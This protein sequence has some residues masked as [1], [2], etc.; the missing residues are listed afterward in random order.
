MQYRNARFLP[1]GRINCEIEHPRHGWIPFT[2]SPDDDRDS[3]RAVHAEIVA[4]GTA[5]PYVHD[6]VAELAEF[7]AM[8]ACTPLQFMLALGETR[9]NRVEAMMNR[10]QTGWAMKQRMKAA[11]VWKRNSPVVA[12]VQAELGLTDIQMDD[13]FKAAVAVT[14]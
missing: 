12:A 7:R 4:A 2:A 10:P 6:P 13:I 11:P 5:V 14:E 3:G 9:W 8:A 1:D